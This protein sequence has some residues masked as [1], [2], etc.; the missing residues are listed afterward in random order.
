[1]R[2]GSVGASGRRASGGARRSEP[3][4]CVAEMPSRSPTSSFEQPRAMSSTTWSC[5]SV[6]AGGPSLGVLLMPRDAKSRAATGAH[7]PIGVFP[8]A[9]AALRG[10][11]RGRSSPRGRARSPRASSS[12][13]SAP[14]RSSSSNSSRRC[15]RIISGPSVAIVNRTPCSTK[16]RNT[17]A[18]R[19]LVRQRLRQQVRGRADLEHDLGVA[20]L[21]HQLLRRRRRGCRGRSGR[22]AAPR[23]PRRSPR[24]R[25][26][27]PPRRRGSSRRARPRAASSTIG[28]TVR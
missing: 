10:S 12:S 21:A 1:M 9:Y 19:V 4:R 20:Q 14:M 15:V 25:S 3:S 27:R 18:D 17:V 11:R 16:V 26:R 8:S 13:V 6:S 24:G 5:R 22:A 7:W 28:C 2:R 23:P